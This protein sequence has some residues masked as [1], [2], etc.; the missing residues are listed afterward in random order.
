MYQKKLSENNY[1]TTLAEPV[2]LQVSHGPSPS[3]SGDFLIP[4]SRLPARNYL[5]FGYFASSM[6]YLGEG[7]NSTVH[8]AK[9]NNANVVVKVPKKDSPTALQDLH[10]EIIM[11]SRVNHLNIINMI[12]AGESPTEFIVLE[13]LGGGTLKSLLYNKSCFSQLTQAIAALFSA[14]KN[15]KL[16]QILHMG[17][18]IAS[19]LHYLHELFHSEA[20]IIHRGDLT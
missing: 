10:A 12:G 5:T 13:Y 6:E 11:L 9:Y 18:D 16:K 14:S 19:A 15:N 20:C 7:S 3:V 2:A 1:D 8:L 17:K 4:I